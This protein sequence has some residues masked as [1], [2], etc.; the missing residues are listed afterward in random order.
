MYVIE[1]TEKELLTVGFYRPDGTW[2]AE[3]DFTV[4]QR[5]SARKLCSFLNGKGEGYE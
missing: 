3:Q 1:Q 5:N 4:S 2:V